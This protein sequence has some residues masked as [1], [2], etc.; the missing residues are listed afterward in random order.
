MKSAARLGD[1]A[2]LMA[3]LYEAAPTTPVQL[4]AA[5]PEPMSSPA[6][7][8]SRWRIGS[9]VGIPVYLGAS[10]AVIAVAITILFGPLITGIV[11][12]VG[13][14]G[15]YAVGAAFAVL[16]LFSVLVHEAAHAL[17][18]RR[19][20]FTVE[21]IVADFWGGHTAYHGDTSRPGASALVAVAG[22]LA[23]LA[24]AAVGWLLVQDMERGV[25]WLLLTAF[26]TAN[27]FVGAFNLLPGLPLDGGF[28][29][30]ALVWKATGSRGM[31][32]LVAGWSGRLLVLGLI[33][34][35]VGIPLLLGGRL[36]L[37][38]LIW[39]ALIC[40]FLWA[41]ASRAVKAGRAQRRFERTTVA[42]VWRSVRH[43]PDRAAVA[44]VAWADSALWLVTGVDG[45][46]S[47]MVD[48]QALRAVWASGDTGT[49][50]SAVSLAQPAGWVV[51]TDPDSSVIDVVTS[52]QQARSPVAA[53]R[54]A[55]GQVPAVVFAADL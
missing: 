40:L 21:R 25:L 37:T 45:A 22:P 9:L 4:D 11:P 36:D 53:I 43:V 34:W 15:G 44:D 18:A 33:W 3:A 50:V 54:L 5:Y 47:G 31:G 49:P 17:M 2:L 35:A 28:L 16:L 23:N 26:T 27:V 10:W 32:S 46:P 30:E 55:S 42:S 20:D 52:M 39:V 51:D 6:R 1:S 41:G 13:R 12:S 8:T 7:P 24:L 19:L 48:D 14:A 38:R 29:L